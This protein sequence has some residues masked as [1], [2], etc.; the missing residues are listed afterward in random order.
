M[1]TMYNKLDRGLTL[2]NRGYDLDSASL[3]MQSI[4]SALDEHFRDLLLKN[5]NVPTEQC[6]QVG[7]RIQVR[8]EDLLTLL[9]QYEKLSEGDRSFLLTMNELYNQVA[10][11]EPFTGSRAQVEQYADYAKYHIYSSNNQPSGDTVPLSISYTQSLS[12]SALTPNQWASLL[13]FS[14]LA[15]LIIP[16]SGL[17]S[18]FIIWQLKRQNIPQLDQHGRNIANWLLSVLIYVIVLIPLH[19]ILIGIPIA[20]ALFGC[21]IVFQIIGGIKAGEGKVWRYPL[22][23]R[24]FK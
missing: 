20:F 16:F 9:Q 5:P 15:N 22:A 3:A 13:H 10:S 1:Q 21:S 7:D 24:F 19:L 17:I 11:G 18:F 12:N 8:W 2:L 4:H 6:N 23:I 14:L